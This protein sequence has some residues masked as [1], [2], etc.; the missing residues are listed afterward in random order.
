M[1]DEEHI[2]IPI[3]LAPGVIEIICAEC[4]CRLEWN[5]EEEAWEPLDV[6]GG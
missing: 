1:E 5:E 2:A 4:S 6:G 3:E